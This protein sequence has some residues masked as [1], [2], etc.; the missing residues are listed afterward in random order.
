MKTKNTMNTTPHCDSCDYCSI[1]G[2]YCHA[3]NRHI[4]NSAKESC[5]L[6]PKGGRK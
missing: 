1:R 4:L 2:T 6:H 5:N 3:R